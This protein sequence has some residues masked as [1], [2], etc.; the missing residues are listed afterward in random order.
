MWDYKAVIF[1][2]AEEDDINE[3]NNVR[4]IRDRKSVV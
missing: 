1:V 3:T 2:L 4:N